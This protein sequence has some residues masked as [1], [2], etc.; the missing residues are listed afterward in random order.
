MY[1]TARSFQERREV[2]RVL[3][4]FGEVNAFRSLKVILHLVHIIVLSDLQLQY[5][6][7]T[8]VRNSFI[9]IY[10]SDTAAQDLIDAS[11]VRYRM[12]NQA[13]PISD[14]MEESASLSDH[15]TGSEPVVVSGTAE[16]TASQA[17]EERVFEIN[18]SKSIHDH[19]RY[20]KEQMLFGPWKPA[21][22]KSSFMSMS[23]KELLPQS[24]MSTGLADW[25]TASQKY[26][27]EDIEEQMNVARAN[28]GSSFSMVFHEQKNHRAAFAT[29][30]PSVMESLSEF[31][32]NTRTGHQA[33]TD[34]EES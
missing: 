21:P 20:I 16:A 30:L 32:K 22:S 1:P 23:L 26:R 12:F 15:A 9:A 10:S 6:P 3:E 4:R 19:E 5:H 33:R 24:L 34:N 8:P 31:S 14:P 13:A 29:K 28:S 2:L 27:K 7:H 25:T 11:P 18:V 17:G